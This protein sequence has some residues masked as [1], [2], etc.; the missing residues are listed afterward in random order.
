MT[1]F[2]FGDIVLVNFPFT[3]ESGSKKRPSV[4]V[5]SSIYHEERSDVILVAITRAGNL[6]SGDV[7]ISKWEEARLVKP[8]VIKPVFFTTKVSRIVRR[9][10]KLEE[11]DLQ[12]LRLS[13]QIVLG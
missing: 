9:L 6:R 4:V 8:S 10:G 5:S 2:N 7:L 13:F 1:T 12:A 3:D 11:P